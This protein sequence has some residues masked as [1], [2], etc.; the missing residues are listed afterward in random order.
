M[1]KD[2]QRLTNHRENKVSTSDLMDLLQKDSMTKQD[3]KLTV[4]HFLS[5]CGLALPQRVVYRN[6]RLHYGITF[7][8]SSI[9][10]YLNEFVD[11]GLCRR[12]EP[13]ALERRELVDTEPTK[14]AAYYLITT[15]GEDYLQENSSAAFDR[16]ETNLSTS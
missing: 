12:V 16:D 1:G 3:R 8:F 13:A 6:M 7:S 11:D 10:N 4:L 14:N 9:N 5:D 2:K 15:E